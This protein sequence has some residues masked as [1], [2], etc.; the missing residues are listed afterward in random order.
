[1]EY[2]RGR[3]RGWWVVARP[4]DQPIHES[5]ETNAYEPYSLEVVCELIPQTTQAH[6]VRV[7]KKIQ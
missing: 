3:D 5:D 1:M 7:V 6:G 4:A 2:R